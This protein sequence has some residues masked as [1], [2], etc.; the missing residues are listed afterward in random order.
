PAPVP[1]PT[2]RRLTGWVAPPAPPTRTVLLRHGQTQVSVQKRFGGS[3]DAPLT[4]TGLA[5]AAAVASRLAGEVFDLVVSSPLKRARQTAEAVLP[6]LVTPD[7]RRGAVE[8]VT[9]DDLRE[10]DFGAWEGLTFA[11]ARERFPD[12]LTAWLA[13]PEVPPPGGESLAATVARVGAAIDRLRAGHP[14]ARLLLVSHMGPIK[15]AT[16]LALAA[17]PSVFY[18]LHLDLASLTTIAWY[19][20]G[21]AVLHAFND[22]SHLPPGSLNGE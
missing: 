2:T 22:V 10:T 15:S 3:I 18:R 19:G 9:D 17:D 4:D 8:L 21:P 12:A 14:G 5:Q 11:E 13:D 7:G 16:S 6:G 1:D 20:D